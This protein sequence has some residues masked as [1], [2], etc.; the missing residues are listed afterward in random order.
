VRSCGVGILRA[1]PGL[2]VAWNK[3][4]LCCKTRRINGWR[5]SGAFCAAGGIRPSAMLRG[6]REQNQTDSFCKK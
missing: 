4:G 6:V 5:R 2:R 1:Q 3:R